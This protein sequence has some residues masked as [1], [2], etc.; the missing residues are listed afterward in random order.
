MIDNRLHWSTHINYI[1][2]KLRKI[3][4]AFYQLRGILNVT[5]IKIVYFAFVQSI[6]EHGIIAWGCA[7]KSILN[8]LFITQ[9]SIIKAG[10]GRGRRYPTDALFNEFKVFDIRQLYIRT[11]ATYIFK[12]SH[13]HFEKVSHEYP[14]RSAM[15]SAGIRVPKLV[16]TFSMTNSSYIAHHL[17]KNLP[18]NLRD[19]TCSPSTCKIKLKKWIKELGRESTEML[20]S[21]IYR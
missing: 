14:T 6:L 9:K 4:Y 13:E 10:I 18:D 17:Y 11:L 16:K 20:I 5:E 19:L 7:F 12:H 2:G 15:G 1:N 8:K 21:S 3:I